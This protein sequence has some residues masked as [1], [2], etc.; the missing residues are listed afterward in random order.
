MRIGYQRVSTVEQ[1]TSR[2]LEGVTVD[3]VF[4]D[5]VSGKDLNRPQLALA[6]G[7]VRDGDTLVI[8]SMDRL[9]RNLE[10]LR[11]I[12]RELTGKGVHVEFV[13]EHLTF[14]GDDS[15]M[16]TLLLSMLG[17]VAE[18]ERSTILERQREGIAIAKAKGK[19][20]GRKAALSDEQVEELTQRKQAGESITSLAS[21]FGISRQT[22]YNYLP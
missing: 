4:T 11:K 19:Y 21:A 8:H 17:A 2:Q 1:N 6:I 10:D 20:K 18:F 12:V 9:A 22:V 7:Y 16:N 5:R 13:K 3:K 14:T 15:P